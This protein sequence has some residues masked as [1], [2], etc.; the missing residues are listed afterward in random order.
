MFLFILTHKFFFKI[1]LV[2]EK[3][4]R[5]SSVVL[6][7]ST[8]SHLELLFSLQRSLQPSDW[9]VDLPVESNQQGKGDSPCHQAYF[10]LHSILIQVLII[11]GCN[12]TKDYISNDFS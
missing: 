9:R 11:K 6:P 7:V 1:S 3:G 2:I 5:W 4:L 10:K 12:K 8:T